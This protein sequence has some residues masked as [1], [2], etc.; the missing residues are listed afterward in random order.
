MYKSIKLYFRLKKLAQKLKKNKVRIDFLS[1]LKYNSYVLIVD[2]KIP[3][4]NKDS[5]SRRLTE[6]I[7]MLL[8]NN[9]GVFLLADFKE[10]KY[11]SEYIEIFKEMGVVVYEPTIDRFNKLITKEGF[12]KEVLPKVDFVWLHRPEI[13][14][15]YYPL[16][17]KYK[18]EAKIFFDM[19]DFHYL[20]FKREFELKG[21]PKMM[22]IANKYL[23]LEL[24]N[25][26]KADRIIVISES[27]KESLKEYYQNNDKAIAIGNIHQYINNVTPVCFE[28]RKELLFIG[29]FDHTP[30]VDAVNYLYEE[31]MPLLWKVLPEISITI[32]GSNPPASIM[33]L[34][35]EK[36][37]IVGYVKDVSPYFLNSRIFVAPLRYGAGIKGKI[38]Q[39]LEYGL[40]LVTTNIGAEGFNFGESENIIIGN[41]SQEIV[42]NI[43]RMYQNEEIWNEISLASQKVI[44]PFSVDT[45]RARVLSLIQ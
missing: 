16:V 38:G 11:Q 10:Y 15:K 21:D 5:G 14:N 40:P 2:T 26:E 39:S 13:F 28:N 20:R 35:S 9:V 43:I 41:T 37:K 42:D 44:E 23:E 12:L 7:K 25:C 29:G 34:N 8:H 1:E 6:I 31:I 3:E 4:F 22:E 27:E 32:I 24:D 45:I 33:E 19:V 17:K 18:T 36:F 30:N